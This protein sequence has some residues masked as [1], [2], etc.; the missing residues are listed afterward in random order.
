MGYMSQSQYQYQPSTYPGYIPKQ[1]ASPMNPMVNSNIMPT[2]SSSTHKLNP[3][4][5]EFHPKNYGKIGMA[6]D[7]KQKMQLNKNAKPYQPN[8]NKIEKVEEK[9]EKGNNSISG[10][11]VSSENKSSNS[12]QKEIEK[13]EPRIVIEPKKEDQPKKEE[14]KPQEE[15]EKNITKGASKLAAL[16]DNKIEVKV[17]VITDQKEISKPV[18]K[19]ILN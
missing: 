9:K 3:N 12:E 5:M 13:E 18:H 11:N 2:E 16:L 1:P 7:T 17:N 14:L 4:A 8:K 10:N 19:R 15:K 6:E